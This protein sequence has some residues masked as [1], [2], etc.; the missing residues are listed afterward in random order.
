V[1]E[2]EDLHQLM[3]ANPAMAAHIHDVMRERGEE[4]AV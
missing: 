2:A 4:R 3:D 1:L